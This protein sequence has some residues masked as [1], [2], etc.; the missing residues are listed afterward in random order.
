MK[1]LSGC[2]IMKGNKLL[3]LKKFKNKYYEFPG[4]KVDERES[5][6]EAAI[7][8]VKEEI[9]CDVN[10]IRKFG[11]FDFIHKGENIQSNIFLAETEDTPSIIEEDIFEK[12]I[13][14]PLDK[15]K[16]Y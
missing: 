3:L 7:R 2:A 12:M 8:E 15:F 10:I 6:E 14:M 13:W 1:K 4:G 9:G 16:E 5:V 11:S